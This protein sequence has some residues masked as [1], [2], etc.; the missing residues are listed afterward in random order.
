M[1]CDGCMVISLKFMICIFIGFSFLTFFCTYTKTKKVFK[2]KSHDIVGKTG[3]ITINQALTRA[4]TRIIDYVIIHELC[5]LKINNH[6]P[7]FWDLHYSYDKKYYEKIQ[8]LEHN[9]VHLLISKNKT[10]KITK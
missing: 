2:E 9:A 4:P 3:T 8:W 1:M 6:S 7:K 10:S 5:H